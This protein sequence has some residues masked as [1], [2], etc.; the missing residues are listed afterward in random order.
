MF[1]LGIL[2]R[3]FSLTPMCKAFGFINLLLLFYITLK[4]EIE[5]LNYHNKRFWRKFPMKNS[6]V[7]LR[8]VF[9]SLPA[10][11]LNFWHPRK[12]KRL[13]RTYNIIAPCH[14]YKYGLE[15]G[16]LILHSLFFGVQV[17]VDKS[18][19]ININPS[20]LIYNCLIDHSSFP[21]QICSGDWGV[22]L[23]TVW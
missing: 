22:I 15:A 17:K 18:S 9:E 23:L 10:W 21:L 7:E 16:D 13:V 11:F 8:R 5:L 2:S 4:Y 19:Y 12:P 6:F 3:N 1:V 14:I 20:L